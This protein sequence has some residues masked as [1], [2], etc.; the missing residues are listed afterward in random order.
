MHAAGP[1]IAAALAV[2]APGTPAA[3]ANDAVTAI[4]DAFR[5]HP[6]VAIDDYHGDERCHAFRMSLIGD[7]RFAEVVNDILVEFGNSRYQN[8]I[9]RFVAGED[10]R[11]QDLRKVWQDTTL[12]HG[13]W[14]VPIYEDFFR[15]VRAINRARPAARR[16][17]V[18]LGDPPI[19]WDAV[20]TPEDLHNTPGDRSRHPAAVLQRESLAKGRRALVIYGGLHLMRHN[21]QGPNL[22]E[23]VEK[24]AGAIAFVVLSHPVASVE[25]AGVNPESLT[26]PALVRTAGSSLENQFDAVLYLGPASGRRPSRLSRELC[27]DPGYREMRARRMTLAGNGRAAEALARECAAA[28]GKPDFSGVWKPGDAPTP[29]A[30]PPSTAGGPPPP[31]P[32]PKVLDLTITQSATELKVNRRAESQGR[33]VVYALTYKLDGTES[34]NQMGSI[35]L[36]T[37]AAWEG[38][39]LTLASKAFVEES[40]IGDVKDVYTLENGNLVIETTRTT[41]AGTFTGKVVHRK[42]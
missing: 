16:L 36:R 41:P 13:V 35:V 11:D 30:P 38:G 40:R 19:D 2:V 34:V 4:L 32:P 31:P 22:I 37:I 1:L 29:P 21:M 39:A 18:L 9:D 6:V 20:R 33:E 8:T 10:V 5:T 7:P 3:S 28:Q 24:S 12:A 15:R 42:Q 26:P 17:R 14:D 27:A 25:A 23:W